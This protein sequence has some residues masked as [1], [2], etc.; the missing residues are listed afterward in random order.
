MVGHTP[1][2]RL[3][4]GPVATLLRVNRGWRTADAPGFLVDMESGQVLNAPPPATGPTP[5][6]RRLERLQLAV[7][8]TQN[9]LLVRLLRPELRADSGIEATLQYALQR[10][11]EQLFQLEESELGAERVGEGDQCSQF[12]STTGP[13]LYHST[14][15]ISP[16]FV[17]FPIQIKK[18]ESVKLQLILFCIRSNINNPIKTGEG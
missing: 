2:L 9:L 14:P 8:S 15:S 7:Q 11:M 3:I 17:S 13:G 6:P 18:L 16:R 10:G 12:P 5:R 1:V 4:Y